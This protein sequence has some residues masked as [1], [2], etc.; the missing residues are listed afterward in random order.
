MPTIGGIA[1]SNA[2][3]VGDRDA[4]VVGDKR[5]DWRG[6][7]HEIAA[8]AG[9]LDEFGLG[10]GDRLAILCANSAEFVIATHAT[11]RLGAIVVPVNTRLAPPEVAYILSD[12]G[13]VM[14]AYGAGEADLA[15]GAGRLVDGV[16]L[17]SLGPSTDHPDLMAGGNGEPVHEDRAAESDDAY[18]LYTSGTTG[19][20]K[21]ALMDHHRAIWA[22]LAQIVSLG[23]RDGD[24]YLH[25]GPMY[26]SGGMTF[27][28]A[29]TLL[30]GTHVIM[31]KFDPGSVL[32]MVERHCVNWLFGVPTMYQQML[33]QDDLRPRDLSSWRVGVFGAAPM[34]AVAV[35]GLIST[36]PHVDFFQ[37]CGQTEAGPTGIYSTM[38][39][40]RSRPDSSGHIAQPF[41]EARVV[42]AD[43]N[44]TPAGEV[45]ELVFRGEAV[46]KGYWRN[47]AATAET[48]RDGWLHT[49]DLM[50]ISADGAMR[51]VDR[52]KDV[53]I[54]GGRN[55][56]SAEVEQAIAQHPD[57]VDVAVIGRPHPEWG[58]TVVAFVTPVEGVDLTAEML[59]EHC[60]PLI[61]D[62]KIPREVVFGPVLRNATGK[63]Q[64]HLL[65]AGV[66]A[67]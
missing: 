57:V 63:L 66:G 33:R 5:W 7:D 16:S 28:N 41:I 30:G 50:E 10:K 60:R 13:A 27:L 56:Y 11:S 31:P 54:T 51:L 59:R 32:E 39:Q 4:V 38:E 19:R 62:Y 2:R 37:Q 18:I 15:T 8:V 6:L 14:L 22:A 61:A 36:F 20:P 45:G 47:P 55:V 67:A 53:I 46:T 64:K 25:L 49:G 52:L 12:S 42:D 23:L 26:H 65:R 24:R 9:A 34:P 29:T 58:A 35:E 44:D 40:V 17:L 3:R 43:G 1:L 48:I 21:G